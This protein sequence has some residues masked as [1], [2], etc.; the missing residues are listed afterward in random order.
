M[1]VP[2]PS[3]GRMINTAAI[4]TPDDSSAGSIYLIGWLGEPNATR[5]PLVAVNLAQLQMDLGGAAA[6]PASTVQT[7]SLTQS[8]EVEVAP[9][10]ATV[11]KARAAVAA[12]AVQEEEPEEVRVS[13]EELIDSLHGYK[14]ADFAYEIRET[15][16][17]V[18]A[19]LV[20]D[21]QH[22]LLAED[23][24]PITLT[25]QTKTQGRKTFVAF[26]TGIAASAV[27]LGT[28]AVSVEAQVPSFAS[29]YVKKGRVWVAGW[30]ATAKYHV[31]VMVPMSATAGKWA[32]K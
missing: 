21:T 15:E 18:E 22:L 8:E 29:Y 12:A 24:D 28:L 13:I 1:A 7:M 23:A 3:E 32:E 16:S 6:V 31:H 2:I 26:D 20:D 10:T 30:D 11:A 9:V 25:A 5:A 27:Q 17:G 14:Q 4:V 19:A